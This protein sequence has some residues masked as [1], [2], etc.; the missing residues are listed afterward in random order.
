MSLGFL[1]LCGILY[2]IYSTPNAAGYELTIYDAFPGYFFFLFIVAYFF[3]YS[4]IFGSLKGKNE[5][6]M[7]FVFAFLL[8]LMANTILLS[9]SN[10]HG[11]W[12]YGRGEGDVLFHI[13][14][15]KDI[16][17]TGHVHNEVFYPILHLLGTTIFYV[18]NIS[19]ENITTLISIMF[20]LCFSLYVY[21]LASSI[22][23]KVWKKIIIVGYS[24]LLIFSVFNLRVHP[25]VLSA[26]MLPLI[27]GSYQYK[28]WA[29]KKPVEFSIIILILAFLITFMHPITTILLLILIVGYFFI[30]KIHKKS[31]FSDAKEL[32][33][34]L[35]ISIAFFAWYL[36]YSSILRYFK[37]IYTSLLSESDTSISNYYMDIYSTSQLS[38]YNTIKYLFW[39]YGYLV[40]LFGIAT[41]FIVSNLYKHHKKV[42]LPLVNI[43][44]SY[45]QFI[46]FL[47]SISFMVGYFIEFEVIRVS[48]LAVIL[49]V[50]TCGLFSIEFIKINKKYI[51]FPFIILILLSSFFVFNVYSSPHQSSPNY[52]MTEMEYSGLEWI[53]VNR[54]NDLQ[55]VSNTNIWKNGFYILGYGESLKDPINKNRN[56]LPTNYG[57]EKYESFND[58]V[59]NE[60]E[61]NE[62]FYTTYDTY[63]EINYKV[64]P[65][66]VWDIA[67]K[68]N[69][70][71]IEM[72]KSVSVIY[73]N[74]EHENWLVNI[75]S[76]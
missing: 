48:R 18:T 42:D 4:V 13:G 34:A 59:I 46:G 29:N 53:I 73:S 26:I 67:S 27:L 11:Y 20:T 1:T 15:M 66:E 25:S 19:F 69:K 54:N 40:I 7:Y 5:T 10:L 6:I 9:L 14:V 17:Q 61:L 49:S 72:D 58:A 3:G 52:H 70:S 39:N 47:I 55:F 32:N 35:L 57:Y 44:Y 51:I 50:I 60:L 62:S 43:S 30:N 16:V 75:Y 74:G 22:T 65:T 33:L 56:K 45:F 24:T 64:L 41:L 63:M 2:V 31:A 8:I 76:F 28:S 23:E 21:F 36:S 38:A 12:L 68:Y 37:I 71:Y